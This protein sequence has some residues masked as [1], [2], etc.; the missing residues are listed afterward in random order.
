MGRHLS[1]GGAAE[2][3]CAVELGQA[4][5]DALDARHRQALAEAAEMVMDTTL[6]DLAA[7]SSPGWAADDW[8]LGGLLPPRYAARF[9]AGFARRFFVCLSTVV[10]KLGQPEPIRPS[11]VAEE[12]AAHILI[13]EAEGKMREQGVEADFGPFEDAFFED[14]DFEF[15]SSGAFDGVEES[16]PGQ[17]MGVANLAFRD[18]FK[19]FGTPGGGDYT[20]VHPY[21]RDDGEAESQP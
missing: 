4:Y 15:L 3:V 19:Q 20:E 8:H 18:W 17:G 13:R 10:W 9:T 6:D 14:L 21:A 7:S 2:G 16:E 12:L 11:C 5:P 1:E